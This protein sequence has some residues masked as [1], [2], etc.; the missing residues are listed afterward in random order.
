MLQA[1]VL[2]E[3]G[4]SFAILILGVNRIVSY[5]LYGVDEDNNKNKIPGEFAHTA[6][7]AYDEIHLYGAFAA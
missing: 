3:F 4:A 7:A 5:G 1:M 6:F 2:G